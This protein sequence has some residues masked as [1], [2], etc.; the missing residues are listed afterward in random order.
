MTYVA[1]E[2]ECIPEKVDHRD[3]LEAG[4]VGAAELGEPY[5]A[6]K[7]ADISFMSATLKQ[8]EPLLGIEDFARDPVERHVLEVLLGVVPAA[9]DILEAAPR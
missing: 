1:S 5:G 9:M 6:R 7:I 4:R 3:A 2:G 8:E